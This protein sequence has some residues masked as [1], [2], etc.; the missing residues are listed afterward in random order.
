MRLGIFA[1]VVLIGA[2]IL[3][4][5]STSGRHTPN[6]LPQST[7][8]PDFN[9]LTFDG[10][11]LHLTDF[12]GKVVV[13]N[14]WASWCRPCKAEAPELQAAWVHYQN[15]NKVV[16]IGVAYEDT[17]AQSRKFI[18]DYKLTYLNGPDTDAHLSDAFHLIGIPETFVI[19][20]N[21]IIATLIYAGIEKN[22]L[23]TI[24]DNLLA[25]E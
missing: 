22:Q 5:L 15:N 7:P 25:T 10:H 20:P 6:K 11:S 14:F 8:A 12:H 19:D 2:L 9:L 16:F 4:S 23:I 3:V 24:V 13:L 18:E 21:G 17:D 1:I